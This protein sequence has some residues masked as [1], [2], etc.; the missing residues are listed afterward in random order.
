VVGDIGRQAAQ[1]PLTGLPNRRVFEL[2]C[3]S[4][5]DSVAPP[6]LAAA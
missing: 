5:I 3:L 4:E 2:A 6:R 1:D